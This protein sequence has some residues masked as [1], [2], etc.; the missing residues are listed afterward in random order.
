M[1]NE[2]LNDID[3]MFI[4]YLKQTYP[5]YLPLKAR[6]NY[7][8]I[9]QTVLGITPEAAAEFNKI[10]Q[11]LKQTDIWEYR[12]ARGSRNGIRTA[13]NVFCGCGWDVE[14]SK[15]SIELVIIYDGMWRF[16][17]RS[18]V[19]SDVGMYGWEAIEQFS[20][21]CLEY[22]IDLEEYRIDNGEE[23]KKEIEEAM[24]CYGVMGDISNKIIEGAH[25]IDF[26]NSYPA[27][28]ANTHPEFRPVIEEFY[29]GRKIYEEYKAVLNLTIGTFQSVRMNG[30]AWAHLSKD[31]IGDNNKRIRELSDRLLQAG[32]LPIAYNTD[33]I[34]YCGDP[35]HG[36]GEGPNLGEWEN[37][38]TDCRI[39]F[40]SKGCYEF[41]E[42]GIYH[43]V[44]RGMTYY[45]RLK[46]RKDWQWGDIFR[47][48]AVP[49]AFAWDDEQGIIQ[50]DPEDKDALGF[51]KK[52]KKQKEKK[53]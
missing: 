1:E 46:A 12:L 34:W 24:I 52:N 42:N 28:L 43:P 22:G 32:R 5:K 29:V 18:D 39:R 45:D 25:H 51:F 35:Y 49:F 3:I 8:H 33:G 10:Y 48:E 13:H 9:P 31:A 11:W 19:K 38:H 6:P 36:E 26:H 40:K 37:D 30:A 47:A 50:V 16:L 21:K 15:T 41:E 4:R 7:K 44:V 17:F 27:G 53:K 23:V 14:V 20:K 2:L